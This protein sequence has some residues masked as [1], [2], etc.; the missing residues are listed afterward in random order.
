MHWPEDIYCI[1]RMRLAKNSDLVKPLQSAGYHIEPCVGQED[2]TVV[3]EV[4][5]KLDDLGG[6]LR[7]VRDVPMYEQIA[8]AAFIQRWWADN[9]VSC[10]VTFDPVTEGPQIK[11]AL[12]YFQYDLKGI[13]LLPRLE[14]GAYAQMPY[15]GITEQVFAERSAKLKPIHFAKPIHGEKAD[16]EPGCEAGACVLPKKDS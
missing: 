4:P 2:S 7:P 6:K 14:A 16:L 15:E 12:N 10:T 1:R 5:V 11:H 8:M 13:S 3:V 9:Q